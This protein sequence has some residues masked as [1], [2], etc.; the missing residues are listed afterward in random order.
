MM[1]DNKLAILGGAKTIERNFSIYNSYGEEEKKAANRVLESGVLSKYL[2]SWHED[3]YG[4]S[5]VRNFE[6]EWSEYFSKQFTV[7]VNSNTSGLI[8]ALGAI[9][10]EPGDE[11]IVSTWTM[12]ASATAILVWNAIPVFADIENDTF[13]IDPVSILQ[14]ITSRTKAIVVTDIFGH[15]A[16]MNAILEIAKKHNLMV[17]E[18]VAQAPGATYYEKYAGTLA[19]I[20]VFSLNYHKHIHTGEGGMCVTDCPILAERMQ[21][22]RNHAEAVV[23]P[24]GVQNI[25]NM[26]G[27]NFRLGEIEAAMGR[28]Q[29]KKLSDL[30][31]DRIRAAERLSKNLRDLQGLKLPTIK[32]GCS[33]VFYVYPLIIDVERLQLSKTIIADALIAEGVPGLMRGYI[34]LHLLPI[35]QKKL[36]YGKSGYP[37]VNRDDVSNVSYHKGICPKAE[38]FQDNSFLGI[39]LCMYNYSNKEIDLIANSF[40]KVWSNLSFLKSYFNKND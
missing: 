12:C 7:A 10:L 6:R 1:D 36:A 28:E 26:I 30:V 17:I 37:W 3:F 34:N 31:K 21:L 4:G 23:G 38:Y 19:D 9:E 25:T 11:V 24:K 15:S 35:Y 18:D 22:I 40:K 8:V 27:F 2:G 14:L 5:E 13:N 29:L 32:E 33:H 39:S 20:G 16:N